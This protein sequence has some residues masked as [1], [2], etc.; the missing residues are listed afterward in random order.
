MTQARNESFD[1]IVIGAGSAGCILADRLSASGRD[2]VLVIE[3]G[4]G[5][6]SPWLRAPLGYAKTYYNPRYNYMYYTEPEAAL[7]GRKLYVPRG[8]VQGGSGAINA[9]IYA[10]GEARDF[11]D[12]ARSGAAGWSFSDILPYFKKLERHPLGDTDHHAADGRMGITSMRRDAHSVCEAFIDAARQVGFDYNDDYNGATLDGACYYQANIQNGLRASSDAAY[13]RPAASRKNLAIVRKA[14]AERILI[15]DQGRARGVQCRVGGDSVSFSAQKEVIVSAGAVNSPKLLQ[16]SGIGDGAAARD[17]GIAVRR[18]APAVGKNLQDHLCVTYM[19]RSRVKTL[20]DEL[21]GAI[22]QVMAGLKYL[23]ARRGPLAM[24]PNQAGGFFVQSNDADESGNGQDSAP[25]G[26]PPSKF[27]VYF[28]PMAYSRPENFGGR[29]ALEPYSGFVISHNACRPTSR[30]EIA[31]ASPDPTAAPLI[32]PNYLSTDK[33]VRDAIAGD[34]LLRR[35]MN[36]P[37]L[38]AIVESEVEPGP[39]GASDPQAA[40]SYFRANAVS[41]YHLCGSCRMGSDPQLS[42]VDARLRVHGVSALR[43]VDASIFPNITSANINAPTMMV[44]E[45]AAAMILDD[46]R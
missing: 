27:Q 10:R 39:G 33:D 38:R 32:R 44:A 42:V 40:L 35:L 24:S 25:S 13:L 20:N 22:G 34:R 26:A 2:R 17:L 43:V 5:S 18:H 31:A 1:Y 28:N 37:A 14:N 9:M 6:F 7:D 8:K 30:G 16:L 4:G 45:K 11:D 12:W 19:Y 15:D 3:A 29:V 21:G 46:G 36:A 23:A 41:I